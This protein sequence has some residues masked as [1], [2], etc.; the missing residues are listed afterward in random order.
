MTNGQLL[1]LKLEVCK[2]YHS[3]IVRYTQ[4]FH[5]CI[6]PLY[7]IPSGLYKTMLENWTAEY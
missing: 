2:M 5:Q 4:H 7:P 6:A 3:L 1:L